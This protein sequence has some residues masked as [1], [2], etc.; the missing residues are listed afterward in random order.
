V[1]GLF[2]Q[3]CAELEAWRAASPHATLDE[4]AKQVTP[5]RQQV[6]GALI[7]K[8]ACQEGN[9]YALEGLCCEQCGGRMVYK[10]TPER[11]VLHLEGEIAIARAYYHCPHC[12]SGVFPPGSTTRAGAP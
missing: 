4:I 12:G 6:M 5:R 1:V 9:G 8:L 7:A 10:G 3:M 11:E 2:A